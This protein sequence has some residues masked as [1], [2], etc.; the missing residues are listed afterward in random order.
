MVEWTNHITYHDISRYADIETQTCL[1]F[2]FYKC[3]VTGHWI[4][5]AIRNNLFRLNSW[6]PV[7]W[8]HDWAVIELKWKRGEGGLSC[9]SI[10]YHYRTDWY[11]FWCMCTY[12][13]SYTHTNHAHLHVFAVYTESIYNCVKCINTAKHTAVTL[14]K[15]IYVLS[16]CKSEEWLT[17]TFLCSRHC[18]WDLMNILFFFL[19]G[20]CL[21]DSTWG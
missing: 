15:N 1:Q 3:A 19:Y 5:S 6:F 8:I 13:H 20:R 2:F 18:R 7:V 17:P 11:L 16:K 4:R 9:C 14:W 12:I 21:S 10:T